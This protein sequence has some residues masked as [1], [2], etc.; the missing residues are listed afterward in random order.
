MGA[1]ENKLLDIRANGRPLIK[2]EP[3]NTETKAIKKQITPKKKEK[4]V[5]KVT[6]TAVID[7]DSGTSKES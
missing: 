7:N 2:A 5:K 6:E 4:P 3:K 1:F